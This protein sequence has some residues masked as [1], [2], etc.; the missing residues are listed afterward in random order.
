MVYLVAEPEY[1]GNAVDER[2]SLVT[3]DYGYDIGQQITEWAPFDVR[4]Q[5][6]VDHTHGILGEY[7][8]VVVCQ[9]RH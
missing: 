6:F 9:K 2:G 1:H 8:E 7:T 3:F 4:I 5:R